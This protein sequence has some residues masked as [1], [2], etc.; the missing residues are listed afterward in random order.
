MAAVPMGS[1]GAASLLGLVAGSELDGV[2]QITLQ[3][4]FILKEKRRRES[5]CLPAKC[6]KS[7]LAQGLGTPMSPWHGR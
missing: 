6:S 4:P 7:H 3:N 1:P 5:L 2:G